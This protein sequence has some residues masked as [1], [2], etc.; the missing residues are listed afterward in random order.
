[1]YTQFLGNY[2]LNKGFVTTE[3]LVEAL[4][5]QKNVHLKL[6]V[7][8]IHA[9]YMNASQVEQIHI[10][11][12]HK[13][14]KFG[15]LAVEVGFLTPEQVDFLL[16]SQKPDYL[17]LSQALVDKGY[18]TTAQFEQA[19]RDYQSVYEITDVDFVNE[20][21]DKI[22]QL[23]HD[24][25][26]LDDDDETSQMLAHYIT[27]LFFN[28]IRFIGKDFTPHEAIRCSVYPTDQCVSQ[29]IT[30]KFSSETAI[31]MSEDSFIAFASRYAGE[32]FE[33]N[34]EYVQASVEDFMNLNNGLYVVNLSNEF[35]IELSLEPPTSKSGEEL[36][37]DIEYFQLP[38]TFP[39]GTVN[40]IITKTKKK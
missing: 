25:Y 38:V 5:Y 36:K 3:Q 10:M 27:L 26:H 34:D 37:E 29:K 17:L 13:N 16:K 12:T 19:M 9:G 18:M 23:I 21:Q 24:F 15:E 11:Q 4:Q 20:Q 28:I 32:D 33:S 39:F 30:G 31:D 40:F 35:S 1:M 7:L 14:G 2:L 22:T 8:A 6:G